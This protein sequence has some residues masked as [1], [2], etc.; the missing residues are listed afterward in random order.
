MRVYR[1]FAHAEK[2]LCW[3]TGQGFWCVYTD[4]VSRT[5]RISGGDVENL[6]GDVYTDIVRDGGTRGDEGVVYT[7]RH[8][9]PLS[10][11]R[12]PVYT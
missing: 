1:R 12:G 5:W 6:R 7:C 3:C 4:I 9:G 11:R 10:A 2:S 8:G